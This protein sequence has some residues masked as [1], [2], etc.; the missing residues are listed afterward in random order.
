MA[1]LRPPP[2]KG[3]VYIGKDSIKDVNGLADGGSPPGKPLNAAKV[4]LRG[5]QAM[6]LSR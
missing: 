1:E 2:H 3:T 6:R 5:P 4:P